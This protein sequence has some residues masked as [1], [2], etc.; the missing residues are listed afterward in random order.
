MTN[1]QIINNIAESGWRRLVEMREGCPAP[2]KSDACLEVQVVLDE[3]SD[4]S[5]RSNR[6]EKDIFKSFVFQIRD[7]YKQDTYCAKPIDFLDYETLRILFSSEI[8]VHLM[9]IHRRYDNVR[10]AYE[11]LDA[12]NFIWSKSPLKNRIALKVLIDIW[13]GS[14]VTASDIEVAAHMHESIVGD[15]EPFNISE[16]VIWP[17]SDRLNNIKEVYYANEKI[18]AP[19]ENSVVKKLFKGVETY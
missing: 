2:D 1:E 4:I 6:T 17:Y 15:A 10:I 16:E 8:G 11:F 3:L 5:N 19:F 13:A 9:G 14:N 12:Q 18:D 7:E